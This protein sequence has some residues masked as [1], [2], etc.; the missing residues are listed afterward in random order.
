MVS[1][2]SFLSFEAGKAANVSETVDGGG[3]ANEAASQGLSSLCSSSR[4]PL[5]LIRD[6]KQSRGLIRV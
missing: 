5:G 3:E 4:M 2:L 6:A 1:R